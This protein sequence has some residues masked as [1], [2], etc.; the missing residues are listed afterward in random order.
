[1]SASGSSGER[2]L[3]TRWRERENEWRRKLGR[4][5]VGVEPV[6]EQLARYRRVMWALV[7]L[8]AFLGVAFISLFTA[9][10]HPGIG[11]LLAALLMMTIGLGARVDYMLLERRARLYLAERAAYLRARDQLEA[12]PP[13]TRSTSEP[14]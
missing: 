3:E 9:F 2:D 4:I 1:L 8:P 14:G 11:V 7:A 12:G 5:R 6:E 13:N 10:R